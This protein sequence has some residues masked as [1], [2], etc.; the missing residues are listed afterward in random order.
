MRSSKRFYHWL[1]SNRLFGEYVRNYLERK[2]VPL[3]VKVSSLA[4]LWITIGCSAALGTDAL[5]IRIVLIAIAVCV[6]A[7]I[8]CLRTLRG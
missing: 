2:G 5:W 3:R 8:L 7:H 4:F 1:T 6:T